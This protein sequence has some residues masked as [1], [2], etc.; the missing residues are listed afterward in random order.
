M[1]R[2]ANASTLHPCLAHGL[3]NCFLVVADF[4]DAIQRCDDAL[5]TLAPSRLCLAFGLGNGGVYGSGF[6]LFQ[7]DV[8]APDAN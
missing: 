6:F 1:L 7:R 4:A 8:V 2:Q 3:G 5:V